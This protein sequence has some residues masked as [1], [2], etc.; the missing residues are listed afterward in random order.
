MKNGYCF[1]INGQMNPHFVPRF[2]ETSLLQH[3]AISLDSARILNPQEV[4]PSLEFRGISVSM[5]HKAHWYCPKHFNQDLASLILV[6]QGIEGFQ[7]GIHAWKSLFSTNWSGCEHS[8]CLSKQKSL[9]RDWFCC[10]RRF[11]FGGEHL[12]VFF[13]SLIF[14][15]YKTTIQVTVDMLSL[16]FDCKT[17]FCYL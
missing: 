9:S 3:D 11:S 2:L 10:G 5:Q 12:L 16:T 6:F 17:Y 15:A 7:K 14:H 1:P 8:L 13:L 4:L